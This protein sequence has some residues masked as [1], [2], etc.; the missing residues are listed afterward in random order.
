MNTYQE[1]TMSIEEIDLAAITPRSYE[2]RRLLIS[3][4]GGELNYGL[5]VSVTSST[6]MT[7][8]WSIVKRLLSNIAHEYP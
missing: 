6:S 8:A 3:A 4:V 2:S 5:Y 1:A 7:S